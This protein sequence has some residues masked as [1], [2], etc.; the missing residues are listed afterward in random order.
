V[1][2]GFLA[3][4]LFLSSCPMGALLLRPL[5][6]WYDPLDLDLERSSE[7]LGKSG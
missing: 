7:W 6:W 5:F 2:V 1:D 4:L 3:D